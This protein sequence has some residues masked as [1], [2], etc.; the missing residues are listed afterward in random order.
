MTW[1]WIPQIKTIMSM[2]KRKK[3][4]NLLYIG[5]VSDN[6]LGNQP[7][8]L[9][10]SLN[11]IV[12]NVHYVNIPHFIMFWV[13]T[14]RMCAPIYAITQSHQRVNWAWFIFR[15]F[16]TESEVYRMRWNSITLNLKEYRRWLAPEWRPHLPKP[17]MMAMVFNTE[18]TRKLS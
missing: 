5:D 17:K 18:A 16:W 15:R 6:I 1:L 10:H 4:C 11:T 12:G 14:I 8:K 9:L 2:N 13:N 7:W 3:C